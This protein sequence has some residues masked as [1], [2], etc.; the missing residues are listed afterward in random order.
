MDHNLDEDAIALSENYPY[1]DI[2]LGGTSLQVFVIVERCVLEA[3]VASS[4]LYALIAAYFAFNMTYTKPL[5]PLLIFIQHFLLGV[6]D[7]QPIPIS[8]TKILSSVDII[9]HKAIVAITDS[10]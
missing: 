2:V 4:A 8:L 5:Y 1:L 7:K 9:K 6:Q 3:V 10:N